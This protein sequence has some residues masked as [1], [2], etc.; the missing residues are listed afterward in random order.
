[1]EKTN[2]SDN[3]FSTIF[4]IASFHHLPNK[5]NRQNAAN[6]FFRI[7][8]PKGKIIVSVWNLGQERFLEEQKA[9]KNRAKFLFNW[10]KDD[11]VVYWG[12]SKIPRFYHYFSENELREIFQKSGFKKIEIFGLSKKSKITIEKSKNIFLLAEK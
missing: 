9:A 4:A 1:M 10:K 2:F 6:E 12:K 5:K 8:E 11:L 7:L 3:F